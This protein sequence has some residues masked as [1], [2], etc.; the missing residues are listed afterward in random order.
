MSTSTSNS[1]SSLSS[2]KVYLSSNDFENLQILLL[3]S[4]LNYNLLL[5]DNKINAPCYPVIEINSNKLIFGSNNIS[6]YFINNNNNNNYN[7]YFED[8]LDI[9]E[10]QIRTNNKTL[11]NQKITSWNGK[12]IYLFLEYFIVLR[13]KIISIWWLLPITTVFVIWYFLQNVLSIIVDEIIAFL[14]VYLFI[15]SFNFLLFLLL[16]F[17]CWLLLWIIIFYFLNIIIETPVP[18]DTALPNVREA[19]SELTSALDISSKLLENLRES[20]QQLYQ[21]AL[22]V[23]FPS[24]EASLRILNGRLNETTSTIISSFVSNLDSTIITQQKQNLNELYE[25]SPKPN[26]STSS[27]VESPNIDIQANG[28]VTSLKS[29]FTIALRKGLPFLCKYFKLFINLF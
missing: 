6:R 22:F 2:F 21:L 17:I 23:L 3:T 25:K 8:L 26:I 29:L 9:E 20:N 11:L 5:G 1:S 15:Y 13:L 28:M 12:F 14:I 7:S 18:F 19:L 27:T 4:K 16:F 24:Y 10:F